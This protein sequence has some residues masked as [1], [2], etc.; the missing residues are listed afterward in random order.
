M[1]L[2]LDFAM[3][4]AETTLDTALPDGHYEMLISSVQKKESKTNAL[5][6]YAAFEFQICS[7]EHTGRKF[8][9]NANLWHTKPTV[10]DMA[11][12]DIKRL[13]LSIWGDDRRI[14][15]LA[16]FLDQ[17]CTVTLKAVK[18]DNGE[19]KSEVKGF[20]K[21]GETTGGLGMPGIPPS[22]ADDVPF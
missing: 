18:Q 10:V 20:M 3:D 14:N 9:W 1:S 16:V 13:T 19:M 7:G 6:S 4:T 8:F 17:I 2:D 12:K 22:A 11:K 15:S 5:N 21:K